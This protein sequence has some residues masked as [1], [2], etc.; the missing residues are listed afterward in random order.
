MQDA[1]VSPEN[2]RAVTVA[3]QK[4]GIQYETLAF[5]DEG[6]GIIKP[7]NQRKLYLELEKFFENS[8]G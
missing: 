1:T 6:H 8:F 7:R 5:E 3:L 4:A 2:V